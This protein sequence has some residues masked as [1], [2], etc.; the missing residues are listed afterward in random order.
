MSACLGWV[1]VHP[2]FLPVPMSISFSFECAD[3]AGVAWHANSTDN[4]A[5]A[6]RP[7]NFW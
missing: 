6:K 4:E 5:V 7:L 3:G 1:D 2:L